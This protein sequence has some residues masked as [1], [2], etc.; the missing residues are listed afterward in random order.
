M[1]AKIWRIVLVIGIAPLLIGADQ[2]T[3]TSVTPNP[4]G[5]AN[6]VK[7]DGTFSVAQGNVLQNVTFIASFSGANPPQITLKFADTNQTVN[8]NTWTCTEVVA[9]GTYDCFAVL[10]TINPMTGKENKTT[11]NTI[12]KTVN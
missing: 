3:E 2:I 12:T 4:G 9:A 8:P 11:S 6:S 5:A 1:L 7:G 10:K